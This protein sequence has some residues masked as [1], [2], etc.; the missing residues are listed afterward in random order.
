MDSPDGA[1][2]RDERLLNNRKACDHSVLNCEIQIDWSAFLWALGLLGKVFSHLQKR[3]TRL[4]RFVHED[5]QKTMC[6]GTI[7]DFT[8]V[9][10]EEGAKEGSLFWSGL[11][12]I[13]V[14]TE[15]TV[16]N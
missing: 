9:K 11:S 3:L 6:F 7:V 4:D 2:F 1:G 13:S 14:H 12:L 15:E 10:E 5:Q 16:L 8:P